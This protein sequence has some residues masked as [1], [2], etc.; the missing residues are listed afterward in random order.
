M[1]LGEKTHCNILCFFNGND[2]KSKSVQSEK[3]LKSTQHLNTTER[4]GSHYL[5]IIYHRLIGDLLHLLGDCTIHREGW[6]DKSM[7]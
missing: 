3:H 5:P 2:D 7:V 4:V 1:I 6:Y